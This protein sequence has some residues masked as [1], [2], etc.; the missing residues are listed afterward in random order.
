MS[1]QTVTH[2]ITTTNPNLGY[3]PYIL[4][5]TSTQLSTY[6]GVPLWKVVGSCLACAA[7]A[8]ANRLMTVRF[9][10]VIEVLGPP[11]SKGRLRPPAA[12]M[13]TA[14][15]APF[16]G[17]SCTP[18]AVVVLGIASFEAAETKGECY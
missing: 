5:K 10:G 17:E 12:D 11:A 13:A 18:F 8:L 7:L 16:V 15:P 2:Y 14:L 1:F 4:P 3:C 9:V 6:S